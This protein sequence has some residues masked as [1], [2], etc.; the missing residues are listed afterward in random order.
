MCGYYYQFLFVSTN[1]QL[2][3]Y[4]LT[5]SI[6]NSYLQHGF[7]TGDLAHGKGGRSNAHIHNHINQVVV[8]EPNEGIWRRT[9]CGDR[10]LLLGAFQ[11][12]KPRW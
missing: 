11:M 12:T 4:N 8:L 7:T 1:V 2:V 9:L 10:L 5:K 6:T 3:T